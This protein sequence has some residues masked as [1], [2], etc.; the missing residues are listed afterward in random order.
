MENKPVQTTPQTAKKGLPKQTVVFLTFLIAVTLV[1]LGLAVY[2]QKIVPPS[3]TTTPNKVLFPPYAH[4]ELTLAAPK[5]TGLNT[6]TTQVNISSGTDKITA[7]QLELSFD[8]KVLLNVQISPG[9]FIQNPVVLLKNVDQQNGR[10]SLALGV[11]LGQKGISGN[12]TIAT[13]TF[14]EAPTATGSTLLD[15]LPKTAVT[16]QGVAQSVLKTS[17]GSLFFVN[18]NQTPAP[19]NTSGTMSAK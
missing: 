11:P 4:T 15:F 17:T 3:P 6:Y 9:S 16:A 1:L 5:Q 18:Q 19:F 12:G 8:P 2:T 14:T 10:I 13:I 7:A